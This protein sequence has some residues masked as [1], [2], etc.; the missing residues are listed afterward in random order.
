MYSQISNHIDGF[1]PKIK[2]LVVTGDEKVGVETAYKYTGKNGEIKYNGYLY[3]IF[4]IIK[5]KLQYKYDFDVKFTDPTDKNY[6][7]WVKKTANGEYDL[8]VGGFANTEQREKIVNFTVPMMNN[9]IGI[10]HKRSDDNVK[11]LLLLIIDMLKPIFLL[12]VL[13]LIFGLILHFIEPNRGKYLDTIRG[14]KLSKKLMFIRTI[15]TTI[16][17]F[18]G[19]MGF[20]SE[21]T[22]L[23][24]TGIITVV[25]IMIIAYIIILIVQA[26]ITTLNVKLQK[27]YG[28]LDLKKLNQY[29]FIGFEGNLDVKKMEKQGANVTYIKDMTLE[30]AVQYYLKN[31]DKYNGGLI[32]AYTNAYPFAKKNKDLIISYE[33]IGLMPEG[34]VVNKD[35]IE[36]LEDLNNNILLLRE[37]EILGPLCKKYLTYKNACL[38]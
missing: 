30:E 10:L 27:D 38:I 32:T 4:E 5:D 6:T 29:K 16:S 35:K 8:I 34:W 26:K 37:R 25:S 23:S 36:L 15:L 18:F 19:E 14:K 9:V 7:N 31:T 11:I 3:N 17:A 20:L 2:V 28:K 22:N 13:G 24:I 33:G 21:N 12:L 1:K